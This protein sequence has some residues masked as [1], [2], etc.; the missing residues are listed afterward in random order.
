LDLRSWCL[1]RS[2]IQGP[3]VLS[4]AAAGPRTRN[5]GR[6]RHEGP[7]TKDARKHS[8]KST[9]SRVDARR[10]EKHDGAYRGEPR[11]QIIGVL[12]LLGGLAVHARAGARDRYAPVQNAAGWPIDPG[13]ARTLAE[14]YTDVLGISQIYA[15]DL[16][17]ILHRRPQDDMTRG[18]ASLSAPLWLD[19]GIRSVD[20]ARR[21][22]ALGV[23]RVIVGL[24]TLPSFD[25]LSDICAAVGGDRV[26]FSLDLHDGE[27]LITS[28]AGGDDAARVDNAAR[29]GDAQTPEEIAALAAISGANTVIVIDLARVG[30]GRGIDVGLLSRIRSAVPGP[31]LVAG[32][33][34][35]GWD[36]LVLVARTGCDAA[37]VA[38][39]L[40][41]GAISAEQIAAAET[42]NFGTSD[43]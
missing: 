39:A 42:L 1:V 8:R 34:V 41:T 12:D 35:R 36:D 15:A 11:L 28:G 5:Q 3:L 29:V 27:P 10:P 20:D 32:G 14:I 4:R 9:L 22:I 7:G 16:D 18:L 25:L 6:T 43:L 31:S 19:A 30:T 24:E 21:A 40:H 13:N 2:V 38:T 17:G 37:L 23:S 33:G 26:A